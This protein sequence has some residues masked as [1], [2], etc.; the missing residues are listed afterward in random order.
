MISKIKNFFLEIIFPVCCVGC[1]R[2][3]DW[4]CENCTEKIQINSVQFCP[5]CWQLNPG[6]RT[7]ENCQSDLDGLRVAASYQ[8]NPELAQAIQTLKYKFSENLAQNLG[9][10]LAKAI[11]TKNYSSERIVSFVPLHKKRQ[12]W[13]GFNQAELLAKFA[14]Q[15]LDLPI[16]NSLIR[17][18]NTAQQAKLNRSER[19]ANL[20]DAFEIDPDFTAKDKTILLVDD[21]ASTT[22]T[23]V[24]AAKTLKQNGAHEV[25]GLVLARK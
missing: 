14:A 2:E 16:Q 5:I 11:T 9:E 4:F 23:L 24:E 19:I 3:G 17:V 7:C 15:Q 1:S 12:R 13:R 21:V 22:T 6:G 25:W 18:K 8:K 10:I 20:K